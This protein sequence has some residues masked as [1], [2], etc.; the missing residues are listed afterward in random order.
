MRSRTGRQH[1][2]VDPFRPVHAARHGV[3]LP[4]VIVL[5]T[6]LTTLGTWYLFS[7]VQSKNV[8]TVFYRDDLARLIAESAISEYR[9]TIHQRLAANPALANLIANPA[10]HP[11]GVPFSLADLP[12][13]AEMAR[14]LL[15]SDRLALEGTLTMRNVDFDLIE[16]IGGTRKRSTFDREYQGTLRFTMKVGLG[17][18][19]KRRF[20]TFIHEFDVKRACLRSPP[21]QRAGRGY[22]TNALNDYV[23]YIRDAYQEFQ[24]IN[25]AGKSLNNDD[26]TLIIDHTNSGK[27]GKIFLGCARENDP[28]R[29]QK[30][31]FI[32]VNE[33]MDWLLPNPP[34]D[35]IIPWADL[36]KPELMPKFTQ[37][38]EAKIEE[39]KRQAQGQVNFT[40]ERVK[41]IIAVEYKPL[42]GTQG[43]WQTLVARIKALFDRFFRNREG[44]TVG[45]KERP[46]HLLGPQ[47]N[48][49]SMCDLIEGNVRQRFWQTAT[50]RMD[51]SQIT[52][53]AQVNQAIMQQV[54][55][56]FNIDLQYY[57]DA[58]LN[59]LW[60]SPSV[61]DST[62]EIYRT[63]KYFENRDKTLLM[64]M[65]N[66][67]FP[68][69]PK[70]NYQT[71]RHSPGVFPNPPLVGRTIGGSAADFTNFLPFA[72]FLV[73][74]YRFA[75]S[76]AL[77]NSHFYDAEKNVLY[78]NGIYMIENAAEGLI[79]KQDLK[80]AGRGV[81]LSYGNITI[82]GNF[83]RNDPAKDGP[84]ILYTYRGNIV[85][86]A[87]AP[88]TIEASLIALNYKFSPT[89]GGG[90]SVVNFSGRK[91][92][93][94][95]NLLA[96]RLNLGSMA[97]GTEN[98]ITYDSENLNGEMLYCTT[99]GGRLRAAR[100]TY[101]DPT[102]RP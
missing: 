80:F 66:D 56:R 1:R 34:P 32:N 20:S 46:I 15:G 38:L 54:G 95:G 41:A 93:V 58:E 68:F 48:D 75:S 96:D 102:A 52:D 35:L 98:T 24:D 59:M 11:R 91:A 82:E 50:F 74:S 25:I 72:P 19:D 33:R 83:T 92:Q 43:W 99:F 53:N 88:G 71:D 13:T 60:N 77:Y 69:K 64:S 81:L 9:A 100:M 90:L 57:S 47:D 63:V 89:G 8:F 4:F 23:L 65:P 49:Q 21:S 14:S 37:E 85:A 12:A 67:Q 42:V 27:R 55:D 29:T 6:I 86:N 78:L 17:P 26:R 39:A 2:L 40:P 79:I 101:D 70:P 84:C 22:T 18:A 76:Q 87:K 31:V 45:N 44:T 62:K 7:T 97:A 28:D 5:I 36:K 94:R 10:A 73:R 16:E 30:F 3:I 61:P 51:F